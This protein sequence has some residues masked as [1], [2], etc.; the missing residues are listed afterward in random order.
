MQNENIRPEV[1]TLVNDATKLLQATVD[2]EDGGG[3]S[4]KGHQQ[5]I[6][7]QVPV[8]NNQNQHFRMAD[9]P[10]LGHVPSF[11]DRAFL[12]QLQFMRLLPICFRWAYKH[13]SG[14]VL[15]TP[16]LLV[17]SLCIGMSLAFFY[18]VENP[19]LLQKLLAQLLYVVP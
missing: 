2:V 8:D 13:I 9:I 15:I 1:I 3:G 19:N 10:E 11:W 16:F 4:P 14:I 7:P 12:Y 6:M 18:V 5:A 17:M